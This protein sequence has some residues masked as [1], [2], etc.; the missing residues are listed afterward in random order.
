MPVVEVKYTYQDLL[1]TPDDGKRYELF[2]GDLVVSPAPSTWHQN[3]VSNLFLIVG[4]FVDKMKLGK[5]FTAPC[6][7]YFREEVIVEPDFLFVSN[8]SLFKIKDEYIEGAPDLVVEVVSPTS[9]VRDNGYKLKLYAEEGVKEYWLPDYGKRILQ[10]YGLTPQGFKL[11][12]EF[13]GD[14]EVNSPL[15]P[16]LSF[17]VSELWK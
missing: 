2:D 16:K 13:R 5:V 1:S 9:T 3:S 15:F 12:G 17:R 8:E 7:V 14:D 4:G 11:V 6:D 10:V